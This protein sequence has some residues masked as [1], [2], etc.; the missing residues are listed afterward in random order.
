MLNISLHARKS[1]VLHTLLHHLKVPYTSDHLTAAIKKHP[2]ANSMLGISDILYEY[3]VESIGLKID[4][5]DIWKLT[6]PFLVQMTVDMY[7]FYIVTDM[8]ESSISVTTPKGEKNILPFNE[9]NARWTGLALLPD[10]SSASGEKNYGTNVLK[11]ILSNIKLPFILILL[12]L[13]FA[14]V[15]F[16]RQGNDPAHVIPIALL[17]ICYATGTF[18]SYLLLLQSID[19]SNPFIKK[20]CAFAKSGGD[21]NDVLDSS[22]A[23]LGGIIS[24]S[25]IGFVFFGGCLL[26]TLIFPA[27]LPVLFYINVLA[28]PYTFWSLFYQWKVIRQWCI[29]CV[30][31]QVLLWAGFAIHLSRDIPYFPLA[32]PTEAITGMLYCFLF[33]VICLWIFM[34]LAQNSNQLLPVMQELNRMKANDM[35]FK[36]LLDNQPNVEF[37]EDVNTIVFGNTEA[38]FTITL[39]TNPLCGPCGEMHRQIK[40]LLTQYR[41]YL[42]VRVIY[43][44]DEKNSRRSDAIRSLVAL[45]LQNEP[46]ESEVMYDQWYA[47]TDK[48]GL[49]EKIRPATAG[50]SETEHIV[51]CHSDWCDYAEINST[52]VVYVN[53]RQLPDW[54]KIEDLRYFIRN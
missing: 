23:R 8:N 36:S 21:C 39:V 3:N 32:A 42:Q 43:A 37:P 29:L 48:D 53:D 4:K 31:V 13:T 2:H 16:L 35:I 28:L 1:T 52:P 24:W 11:Q 26:S 50:S 10:A 15:F 27:S 46:E 41:D 40:Q 34:P 12:A 33:L 49:L 19:R 38:S 18:V 30:S 22:A 51:R 5:Q 9:F 20:I 45:Y 54:Y 17:S 25:A 47:S 7:S 6:P 14:C 44:V